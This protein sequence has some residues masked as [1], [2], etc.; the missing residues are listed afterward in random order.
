[1]PTRCTGLLL[2]VLT[3]TFSIAVTSD[4]D[5][6]V[7]TLEMRMI[8]VPEGSFTMG[9]GLT[10]E[11]FKT[12]YG[13]APH[14]KS[15]A[16]ARP[17]HE[18][19]IWSFYL[20]EAEVTVRQFDAFVS[21]TGYLTNAERRNS[22][23]TWK[24][25][26][27]QYGALH[28][29]VFVSYED[30]V[31]FCKWLSEKEKRTYRLPTEAEWEYACRAGTTTQYYWGDDWRAGSAFANLKSPDDA[32][33]F[34]A[35][36]AVYEANPWGFH[37]MVGNVWEWCLDWASDSYSADSPRMNP[38]GSESGKRRGYRGFSFMD[39]EP[40]AWFRNFQ[41]PG[42]AHRNG[43]FRVMSE[44]PAEAKKEAQRLATIRARKERKE[45]EQR[46]QRKGEVGN[47]V[48]VS[49]KDGLSYSIVDDRT[50]DLGAIKAEVVLS[51][52]AS[53]NVTEDNLRQLLLDLL[54]ET[55]KRGGYTYYS[56]PS[57]VYIYVYP[58][59]EHA[60]GGGT[61]IASLSWAEWDGD[62]SS[63]YV[64][65]E[66]LGKPNAPTRACFGLSPHQ[67]K[68]LYKELILAEI[69]ADID[70]AKEMP[71]EGDPDRYY[72]LVKIYKGQV[73]AKYGITV[74]QA[75]QVA[76]EAFINGWPLPADADIP[77]P[78]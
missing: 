45:A 26:G 65:S 22:K 21:R 78:P 2:S 3:M 56:H 49:T 14:P 27:F 39:P 32:D 48:R 46:T 17:A 51:L 62:E 69:Q 24:A 71:S 77:P 33:K 16:A 7:N 42:A 67:Q 44:I 74:D 73:A 38:R 72:L 54:G 68:E 28:P 47:A 30:A 75:R 19:E 18:V 36:V 64:K 12:L 57:K 11:E 63:I 61:S 50:N 13:H 59:E 35:P 20:G 6:F 41:P 23:K 31:E 76:D 70:T 9:C 10:D 53:G 34:T 5:S 55:R 29:V 60:A 43:G 66:R 40:K 8:R 4:Q 58:S 15:I 52:V 1:M 25:P 37:D